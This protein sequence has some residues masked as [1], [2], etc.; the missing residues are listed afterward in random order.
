MATT[1]DS[2]IRSRNVISR[3]GQRVG[4]QDWTTRRP[5]Q[6]EFE[7]SDRVPLWRFALIAISFCALITL[8]LARRWLKIRAA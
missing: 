5:C 6:L 4:R 7:E 8:V 1:I 3:R 2:R